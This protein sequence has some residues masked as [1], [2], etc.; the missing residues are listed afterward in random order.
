M[1]WE[2]ELK[3]EADLDQEYQEQIAE[4]VTDIAATLKLVLLQLQHITG[5]EYKQEDVD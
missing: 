3:F 4:A 1:D 5:H 2:G